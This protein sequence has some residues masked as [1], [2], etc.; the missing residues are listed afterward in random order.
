[1]ARWY[2]VHKSYLMIKKS[3][4]SHQV[5]NTCSLHRSLVK[6]ALWVSFWYK[7][8]IKYAKIPKK[9]TKN[10]TQRPKETHNHFGDMDPLNL[11]LS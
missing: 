2:R 3:P 10:K 1:M 4:H 11:V 8:S 9:S 6:I 7:G 5:V